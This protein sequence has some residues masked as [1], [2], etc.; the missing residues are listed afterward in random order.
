[1]IMENTCFR[2]SNSYEMPIFGFGTFP[3]KEKLLQSIPTAAKVGYRFVDT[4]DDYQNIEWVGK[5]IS[6]MKQEKPIIETKFSDP[7]MLFEMQKEYYRFKKALELKDDEVIDILLLHFPYP[8]VYVDMWKELEKLYEQGKCK[9]IGVCNFEIEHLEI[10]KKNCKY[11]PMINQ[12]ELHPTFRRMELCKYCND[13]HIA[14]M[15]YSPFARMNK[16]LIDNEKLLNIA[17]KYNKNVPQIIIR[18][19]LQN[20]YIPIPGSSSESHIKSNIDVFDFE[21]SEEDMKEIDSIDIGMRI[22]YDPKTKWGHRVKI[23]NLFIHM[24]YLFNQRVSLNFW[25]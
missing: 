24:R 22:R 16:S 17:K 4:S 8:Y 10:L 7:T 25:T 1:M 6:Q 20:G 11:V 12:F 23:R 19:N 2:L 13:N 15:S 5:A 14:I 21:L 3:Q 18:W 9:V